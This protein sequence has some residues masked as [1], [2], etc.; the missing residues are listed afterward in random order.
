MGYDGVKSMRDLG[1]LGRFLWGNG[2]VGV[3][4]M[5]GVEG[6]MVDGWR[7][8]LGDAGVNGCTPP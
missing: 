6:R 2:G 4:R 5:C 1:V 8:D 3:W 7:E